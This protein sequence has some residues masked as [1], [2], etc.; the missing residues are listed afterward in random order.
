MA[1]RTITRLFIP[2][3]RI[4]LFRRRKSRAPS[5][6]TAIDVDGQTLRVVQA[7]PRGRHIAMHRVVSAPLES[8]H[9]IH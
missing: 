2:T 5:L 1:K 7:S 4:R 3:A 6:I 8:H 9:D